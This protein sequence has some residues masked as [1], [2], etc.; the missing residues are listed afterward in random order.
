VCAERNRDDDDDGS[1]RLERTVRTQSH[2]REY[3]IIEARMTLT[4]F[5][6][7]PMEMNLKLSALGQRVFVPV[8]GPRDQ[9]SGLPAR[10]HRGQ[11]SASVSRTTK[12]KTRSG[13]VT[14]ACFEPRVDHVVVKNP[15]WDLK[16]FSRVS[17]LLVA[18]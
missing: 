5:L 7:M 16:T 11:T 3:C 17:R 18:A 13:K 9:G 6:L 15:C 1:W 4:I 8:F 10:P 2:L 14:S 12:S